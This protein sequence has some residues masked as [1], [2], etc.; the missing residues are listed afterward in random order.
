MHSAAEVSKNSMFPHQPSRLLSSRLSRRRRTSPSHS[1][2]RNSRRYRFNRTSIETPSKTPLPRLPSNIVL[3]SDPISVNSQKY[4]PPSTY[5][6]VPFCAD[7]VAA[8][9]LPP[10]S[11]RLPLEPFVVGPG[12]LNSET[13]ARLGSRQRYGGT[14]RTTNL[15]GSMHELALAMGMTILRAP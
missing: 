8:G 6:E 11:E 1:E 4:D 14:I 13:V 10:I 7:L 12:V 15:N 3:E 2:P 9:K 5:N